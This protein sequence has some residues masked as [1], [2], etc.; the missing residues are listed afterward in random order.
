MVYAASAQRRRE[1]NGVPDGEPA[2]PRPALDVAPCVDDVI[3]RA[4]I[5]PGIGIARVG[6]AETEFY[7]GPEVTSLAQHDASDYRDGSGA[8][9]REAARFRI[10]GFNAAGEVVRELTVNNAKIEWTAHIAN[11]K[12]DW[13][14]FITAMDIP[15]TE[16]LTLI[17]RN[18]DLQGADREQLVIDPGNRSISG[19]S[20][21]GDN[22]YMFDTGMFKSTSVY[23]GELQT[24][25]AGRLLVLGGR[26]KSASPSGQPPF[27]PQEPDTFNNANDWFDDIADGPVDATVSINGVEIPVEGAWVV[28]AP[29][30]YAPDIDRLANDVRFARRRLYRLRLAPYSTDDLI[31][32]GR[33]AATEAAVQSAMGEQGLLQ[34]VRQGQPD[35]F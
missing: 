16:D 25:E 6:D 34:H 27:D 3:V 5:H 8:L 9:K 28:V 7:M 26:G 4:A 17:R 20:K 11:R 31:Y 21:A 30:N 19:A 12:A 13:F 2:S 18:A 29:P 22:A 33:V 1:C 15:E 24:D 32:P 35:G 14:R 23:L 10:Y